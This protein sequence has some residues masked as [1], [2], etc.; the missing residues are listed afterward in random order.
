MKHQKELIVIAAASICMA[1]FP[2]SFEWSL[3]DRVAAVAN[4]EGPAR[5]VGL[6]IL[7]LIA[8]GR[9]AGANP[10]LEA[11]VGLKPGQLRGPEFRDESVRSHALL[12]IGELDVPE[13]LAYL[14]NLKAEDIAPDT[15]GLMR[16]SLHI[17]LHQAQLNRI[18]DESS[19]IRFLENTTSEKS[20]AAWWA[21]EQL[22]N[23]GSRESLAF[24]RESIWRRNP[25]P[26]GTAQIAFCEARID[27]IS[28]D[29]DRVKALASVLSVTNG[30]TD[31]EL[32]GWAI[33]CAPL[34]LRGRRQ[35]YSGL[36]TKLRACPTV[37]R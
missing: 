5:A 8:E 15:S 13:A 30:V 14:Q 33:S 19:K 34:A 37:P 29:P 11:S 23:R 16:S 26:T 31:P 12:K 28:R 32:L 7:E 6:Q 22:C 2:F 20:D 17:A 9:M 21:V 3:V 36:R 24:I 35:R 18:P 25:T 27:V 4:A 1:S 10:G